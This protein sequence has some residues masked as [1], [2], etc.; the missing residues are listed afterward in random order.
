[1]Y[2]TTSIRKNISGDKINTKIGKKKKNL[3]ISRVENIYKHEL[4]I[5]AITL[6]ISQLNSLPKEQ[7][8]LEQI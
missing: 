2:F 8:F 3:R 4:I 7:R 6:N 5:Q 1:M